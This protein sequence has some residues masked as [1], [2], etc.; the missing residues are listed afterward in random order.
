MAGNLMASPLFSQN[1]IVQ[2]IGGQGIVK[3]CQAGANAWNYLIEMA[4]GPEPPMGRIGYETTILLTEAD[5]Q[6]LIQN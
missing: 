5:I 2:F 4:M 1:Q 3:S 6:S